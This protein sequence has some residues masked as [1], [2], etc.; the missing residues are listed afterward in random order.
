LLTPGPGNETYFEHAFLSNYLGCTLVQG[1]DLT[2]RDQR[3]WLRTLEG[4]RPVDVIVRRVD[5]AYCDPLEMRG[6]SLLGTPGLLQAARQ[7]AV[8]LINP[9][10]CSVIE[11]PAL[12]AFL[13]HLARELLG[14]DLELP[15]VNTWWCGA[16]GGRAYVL[17]HL[18]RLVVKP[19][20]R[21]AVG[22]TVFGGA[23]N[24]AQRRE[25]ADAITATPHAFVGQQRVDV[26]TAPAFVDARLAPRAM[27][28]RTFLVATG[29]SYSVMPGG[30]CR[31]AAGPDSWVVSNQRGGG[32][33]DLWVLAMEAEP[34]TSLFVAADRPVPLL[35]GGQE[36]PRRVADDLFWVGRYAE[37]AD[38]GARVLREA[39][40]RVLDVEATATEPQLAI[41]LRAVTGITG[42]WPGFLGSGAA[43]RLASPEAELRAV[44]FDARRTGS[45]RF[46]I[47]AL[48]RAG[49]GMRDRFSTDTWR[50]ISALDREFHEPHDLDAALDRL[51]GI[52]LLLAAFGGLSADSMSRGQRWRFL[53]IGRRLERALTGVRLLRSFCP[54]GTEA[55]VVPWEA[56]LA[57]ADASVTYRRRYRSTAD[58]GAA[59][60]LIVDDETNPR[61]VVYQ[62]LQLAALLDGLAEPHATPARAD[63]LV[64]AALAT[65]RRTT[66]AELPQARQLDGA[67][68]ETLSRVQELLSELSDEL[69]RSYF[70]QGAAPRQLVGVA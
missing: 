58:P 33:K 39:V 63:A 26:S 70:S 4:L 16:R 22:P 20:S 34:Q 23:L 27:V 46:N 6:D 49:R 41:L 55:S 14:E 65:L 28:L 18:E 24:A 17:E 52:L 2:V 15:S 12:M 68:D 53:E 48:V 29:A 9:V 31:I 10:G 30:L 35:R 69:T 47:V 37:R 45:L 40:R 67:L 50:V 19:I 59:V 61:S 60:D 56:L 44:L 5:D 43:E 11:N 21:S 38:A 42:T 3:V 54:P 13:P 25:L 36:V 66:V 32:S 7:G 1:D 51:D 62:L 8:A 57:I 64:S